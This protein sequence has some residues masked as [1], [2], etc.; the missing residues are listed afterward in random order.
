MSRGFGVEGR[1]MLV[2]EKGVLIN[3]ESYRFLGMQHL[4]AGRARYLVFC[5]QVWAASRLGVG[6]AAVS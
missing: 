1:K 3:E 5:S 4:Q 2:E 6:V